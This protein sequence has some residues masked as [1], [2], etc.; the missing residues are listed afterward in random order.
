MS[1]KLLRPPQNDDELYDLVWT[2]W[3]TRIPRH[4]VCPDHQS[5]FDAFADAYFARS[6]VSVW[7]ASRGFGGKSRTLAY[8]VLTEAVILGADVNLLGGSGAQSQNIHEAMQDGWNSPLAPYGMVKNE[9][10]IYTYLTNGAKVKALMA[11]QRSVR[12][13]HPQRLRMDEIDEMD[14]E[15]LDSALGQ[16]MESKG[17]SP[18]IVLSS[19]HQYPDKTMTEMIERAADKGWPVYQWCFRETSNPEDGW[20][21][22]SAIDRKRQ[23]VTKHMWEVEYDLQEPSIG[24]RAF[25]TEMVE[26]MFTLGTERYSAS[27]HGAEDYVFEEPDKAADYVTGADWAKENDMT[28]I[29]T[30]R[31]DCKPWRLVA[32]TRFNR[33]PY[34]MMVKKMNERIRDYGGMAIHDATGLGNVVSDYL[35]AR[36][37]GFVMAGR[38]RDDMLTEYIAAVERGELVAPRVESA[39]AAHKYASIEDIYRGGKDYH[40]PDEV[41]AFALC[42]NMRKRQRK[43]VRASLEGL[44]DDHSKWAMV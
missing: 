17:I 18:H 42:W 38:Q 10:Q 25:D 5:P 34:P 32:Y 36:V 23:E 20:L 30:F 7:K 26:K 9:T 43:K 29:A 21:T 40:L 3:G 24:N 33:R 11:S 37:K 41:C 27:R 28:V 1:I 4:P 16:P 35:D 44:V 2:L 39:Y 15:I 8:L 19:T 13:P 14:V 12:G 31:T 6:P 22:Q